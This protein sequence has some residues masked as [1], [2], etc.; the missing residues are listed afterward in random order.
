V[1]LVGL[2]RHRGASRDLEAEAHHRLVDR[3]DLLDVESAV[4]KTL[5]VEH[6]QLLEYAL[7]RAVGHQRW[8]DPLVSLTRAGPWAALEEGE[9]VGVEEHAVARRQAQTIG[10]RAVMNQAEEHQELGPGAEALVHR[11][12][13]QGCIDTQ[14]LVQAGERVVAQEG[15]VRG[16]HVA[17]FRVEQE[18]HAQQNRKQAAVDLVGVLGQGLSQEA[19]RAARTRGVVGGL[20]SAQELV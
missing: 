5:A 13:V 4:G 8:V 15:L 6:E 16:Q 19:G 14:A 2:D 9:A 3:A 1:L 20:E 7:E 11:V 18:D 12:R 10:L 17:L